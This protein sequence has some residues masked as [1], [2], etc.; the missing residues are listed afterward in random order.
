MKSLHT[1]QSQVIQLLLVILLLCGSATFAIAQ[2][3][4]NKRGFQPG[5]SYAMGDLETINTTNGNLMLH[6][7]LASLPVGRGG[8]SASINLIYNS[9]LYDSETQYFADYNHG[10]H[11]GSES[12]PC[13]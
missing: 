11:G 13:H 4:T 8:L 12:S 6:F 7:P 1:M 9:K 3:A 5:G 2:D 10:C